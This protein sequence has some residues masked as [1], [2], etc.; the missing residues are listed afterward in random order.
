MTFC[1]SRTA[2]QTVQNFY[3]LL[4]RQ[5]VGT[6]FVAATKVCV[7]KLH[8]SVKDHWRG[9]AKA[10][11]PFSH[12]M[13]RVC[14]CR[15]LFCC[16]VCV[17]VCVCVC[18]CVSALMCVRLSAFV[19]LFCVLACLCVF[20]CVVLACV[21]ASVF[22]SCCVDVRDDVWPCVCLFGQVCSLIFC[23]YVYLQTLKVPAAI[24]AVL[25][26]GAMMA[27]SEWSSERIS[28]ALTSF[29]RYEKN[30]PH[31]LNVDASGTFNF[32]ELMAVW[33]FRKGL[34]EQDVTDALMK[35]C[36]R[37]QTKTSRRFSTSH[38]ADGAF[39]VHVHSRSHKLDE[40]KI[41]GGM[42]PG[43]R[44]DA[45]I[46]EVNRSR[47]RSIC[48]RRGGSKKHQSSQI[49]CARGEREGAAAMSHVRGSPAS[50]TRTGSLLP[51]RRQ[52]GERGGKRRRRT[53]QMP[54][55]NGRTGAN[56]IEV[57][58]Q[59]PADYAAANIAAP[60]APRSPVRGPAGRGQTAVLPAWLKTVP[61]FPWTMVS[62]PSLGPQR[63]S[64]DAAAANPSSAP[65]WSSAEAMSVK[66]SSPP[67]R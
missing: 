32:S 64:A 67:P 40:K 11:G 12:Q 55:E 27:R 17:S 30:R 38:T 43:G 23:V 26:A 6:R 59:P 16:S 50:R 34:E 41:R 46:M 31:G 1:A 5:S 35:H 18:A 29:G 44:T 51:A 21:C 37:D 13:L 14:V 61:R 4:A 42:H 24:R 54:D 8:L 15:P 49:R 62:K 52:R 56:S 63:S 3:A 39:V 2:R 66:P 25:F 7:S 48:V 28:R 19:L 9:H 65:R 20:V 36:F 60:D 33:G 47:R 22:V 53:L 10:S 58:W 45:N 57:L